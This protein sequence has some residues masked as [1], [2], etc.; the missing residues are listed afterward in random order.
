MP[1]FGRIIAY[2]SDGEIGTIAPEGGG[3]PLP[4]RKSDLET[5]MRAPRID[6]RFG[7]ET[8]EINGGGKRAVFLF[9]QPVDGDRQREQA[10]AQ[11]G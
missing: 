2:D 7:Y 8:S 3:T 11:R 6:Q 4:F 5:G 10:I 9:P 1:F